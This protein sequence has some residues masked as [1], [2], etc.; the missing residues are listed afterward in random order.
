MNNQ[1]DAL[2]E[3]KIEVATLNSQTPR[4]DKNAVLK[5]L[6]SGHP[7]TRLL[8]V[9]PEYCQLDSFRNLLRLVHTQNELARV[10]VDE[11]HC[12]SEWGHD[13]RTSYQ[14]LSWFKQCFPDVP[15]MA[16]TATATARVRDDII[17]T[18]KLDRTSLKVYAMTSARPNLHYEIRFKSNAEDQYPNFLQ[19]LNAVLQRRKSSVRAAELSASGG[20]LNNFPGIIYTL[21][22]H[23]CES[24]AARLTQD[25]IGAK[26]FHAGLRPDEKADHL[27]NWVANKP[28]Y[29]VI[30]ATIAFGMGID[31]GDVRFVTHWRLPKTFEG[32]YQEAG[33][34]GRDGKASLCMLYYSRED[35]DLAEARL[36]EDKARKY[37]GG[38]V[39]YGSRQA[40]LDAQLQGRQ[41]SLHALVQYCESTNKC[42]HKNICQYFGEDE[43]AAECDFACDWCKDPADVKRRKNAELMSEEWCS[44]QRQCGAYGGFDEY[45]Y[46]T[47]E[48]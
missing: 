34:A 21:S 5:D 8:Y 3:R 2:R 31:K 12:I 30:V 39:G 6:Q 22:R 11:A 13:F 10:A 4:P 47:V 7:Y 38:R 42:R 26:P 18:L 32:Y 48:R 36:E 17:K 19:W 15:M 44:T 20:R 14:E 40:G 28:G 29:D 9:T 43:S 1:V 37:N 16:L 27:Q 45:D 33:R 25:G 35:R 41:Q 46:D 24:L 23:D